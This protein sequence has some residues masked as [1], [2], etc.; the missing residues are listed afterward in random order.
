MRALFG[1]IAGYIALVVVIF[2]TL[3][4]AYLALG[5]EKTFQEGSW[6]P[7]MLWVGIMLAFGLVAALVGG[8]VARKIGGEKSPLVLAGVV[9]VLGGLQALSV[10]NYEPPAD[11]PEP[12]PADVGNFESMQYAEQPL[13]FAIANPLVGVLGVLMGGRRREE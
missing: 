12:R 7:S 3:T 11:R 2:A 4:G 13:W 10:A 6:S 9:L 5:T 1:A 8:K